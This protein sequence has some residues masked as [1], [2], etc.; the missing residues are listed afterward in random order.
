MN[1]RQRDMSKFKTAMEYD[2][3]P[4]DDAV[5]QRIIE[6]VAYIRGID[7]DKLEARL[8]K[9]DKII[10]PYK[11]FACRKKLQPKKTQEEN[12]TITPTTAGP[13]YSVPHM[14][15]R[16]DVIAYYGGANCG[17]FNNYY[18]SR[19]FETY[20]NSPTDFPMEDQS[21]D[22]KE[23]ALEKFFTEAA[24]NIVKQQKIKEKEFAKLE[25]ELASMKYIIGRI[26]TYA[27]MSDVEKEAEEKKAK[28]QST[29]I[30]ALPLPPAPVNVPDL[31]AP[32]ASVSAEPNTAITEKNGGQSETA[33]K[34]SLIQE[35]RTKYGL[36]KKESSTNDVKDELGDCPSI[37]DRY[38]ANGKIVAM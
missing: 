27:K 24:K 14:D 13:S 34:A 29:T 17:E 33:S 25:K 2:P 4:L 15:R 28:E 10:A 16:G 32:V 6:T 21:G 12:K 18:H 26:S 36:N 20:Y 35:F 23:A 38:G 7:A 5:K 37:Q 9:E 11:V 31:P 30:P 8:I 1:E 19:N 22:T 3:E